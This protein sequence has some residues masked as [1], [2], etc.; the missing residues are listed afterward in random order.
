MICA[1]HWHLNTLV[2]E[3]IQALSWQ[4]LQTAQAEWSCKRTARLDFVNDDLRRQGHAVH[5]F[6]DVDQAIREYSLV[7]G[8]QLDPL[9]DEPRLSDFYTP[10][11]DQRDRETAFVVD[12]M[13]A[14]GFVAYQLI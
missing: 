6:Q 5:T 2:C 1:E 10:S 7:T 4:Q 14:T 11:D 12:G 9:G 8:K 13:V 3:Q